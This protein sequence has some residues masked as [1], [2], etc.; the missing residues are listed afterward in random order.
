[1]FHFGVLYQAFSIGVWI[2]VMEYTDWDRHGNLES[3]ITTI[4]IL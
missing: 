2:I 4:A 3:G 1:M